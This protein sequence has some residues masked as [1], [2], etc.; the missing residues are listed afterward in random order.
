M[1]TASENGQNKKISKRF[2]GR[3]VVQYNLEGVQI[4]TWESVAAIF[5]V[6]VLSRFRIHNACINENI[7]NDSYWRYLE[8]VP[9]G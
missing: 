1:G 4:K 7:M 9:V 6:L 8:S 2:V 3:T 5:P